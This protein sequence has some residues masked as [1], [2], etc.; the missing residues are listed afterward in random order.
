MEGRTTKK[1]GLGIPAY[2]RLEQLRKY[3]QSV[4]RSSHT[5]CGENLK[6]SMLLPIIVKENASDSR[7]RKVVERANKLNSAFFYKKN[8][9]RLGMDGN[10]L[11]VLPFSSWKYCWLLGKDVRCEAE[12]IQIAMYAIATIAQPF[13]LLA[14]NYR[15]VNAA[16]SKI[17]CEKMI[18]FEE[19]TVIDSG[20]WFS[21][22]GRKKGFMDS[23]IE[24]SKLFEQAR[25]NACLGT[26]HAAIVAF[27]DAAAKRCI[28]DVTTPLLNV[29]KEI[30]GILCW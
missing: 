4:V 28:Q 25:S 30:R 8:P 21:R 6:H 1:L 10:I 23:C 3:L 9:L 11:E 14:A 20:D 7:N 18:P 17:L 13:P 26:F 22:Y 24:H 19:D 12:A 5:L 29:K 15:Y 16:I 2:Q 27:L